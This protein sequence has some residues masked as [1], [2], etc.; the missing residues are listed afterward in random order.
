MSCR[1]LPLR[2][3]SEFSRSSSEEEGGSGRNSGSGLGPV[4][5]FHEGMVNHYTLNIKEK[6]PAR[7]PSLKPDDRFG[8]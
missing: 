4:S 6:A 5:V 7:S 2:S 1:Q 3:R 8:P